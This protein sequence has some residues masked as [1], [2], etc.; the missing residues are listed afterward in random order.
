MSEEKKAEVKAAP[1]VEAPKPAA[2]KVHPP[3]PAWYT[4]LEAGT[5]NVLPEGEPDAVTR[6]RDV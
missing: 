4:E 1:K 5:R 3:Q 6:M 2:K